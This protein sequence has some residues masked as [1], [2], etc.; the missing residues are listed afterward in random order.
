MI[1]RPQAAAGVHETY[2][3]RI[4]DEVFHARVDDGALEVERGEAREPELVLA[5][6]RETWLA[7]GS[8]SLTPAEALATGRLRA[9]GSPAA[10]AHFA[11][12]FPPPAAI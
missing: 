10:L 12:I 8:A 6:D 9:E 2:E 7:M 1:F 11:R 5:S 3:V 4:D